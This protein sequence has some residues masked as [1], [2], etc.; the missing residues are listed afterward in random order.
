MNRLLLCKAVT[1]LIAPLLCVL[2]CGPGSGCSQPKVIIVPVTHP[3]QLAEDLR[4]YVFVPDEKGQLVRSADR[5][6][7]YAGEWVLTMP[8]E[9]KK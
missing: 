8:E 2:L 9:K 4:G 7:L 3:R 6:P 1:M 5:V